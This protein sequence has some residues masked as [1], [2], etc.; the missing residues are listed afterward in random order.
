[1]RD[2]ANFVKSGSSDLKFFYISRALGVSWL[3]FASRVVH[4]M[5]ENP[6]ETLGC[7][8]RDLTNHPLTAWIRWDKGPLGLSA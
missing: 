4:L 1:M 8:R 7:C 5:L 6:E 2:F 3:G